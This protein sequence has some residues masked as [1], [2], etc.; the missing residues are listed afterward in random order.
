MKWI[1]R[2]P[3]WALILAVLALAV[4]VFVVLKATKPAPR[5]A[6]PPAPN[7]PVQVMEVQPRDLTLKVTGLGTVAPRTPWTALAQVGGEIVFLSENL[8]SGGVVAKGETLIRID[9]R[10]YRLAVERLDAQVA[11]A[12]EELRNLEQQKKNL[13]ANLQIAKESTVLSRRSLERAEELLE[14][15]TG[16]EAQRD[17]A[18]ASLLQS[19]TQR[20][21][22]ENQLALWPSQ[23]ARS[24]QYL[25]QQQAMLK[26]ARIQLEDTEI[27]APFAGRVTE[28]LREMGEY[29][30]PGTA[31]ARLYE[32]EILEIPVPLSLE[33]IV[34]VDTSLA[35]DVTASPEAIASAP[36]AVVR[37]EVATS[38]IEWE[39]WLARAGNELDRQSR[40]ANLIVAVRDLEGRIAGRDAGGV[41]QAPDLLPGSFVRVTIDGHYL[42]DIFRIPRGLLNQH[43]E[44]YLARE[45]TLHVQ[46][47]HVLHTSEDNAYI[48]EGLKAGDQII[49]S[50]VAAP[51]EGMAVRI[52][53]KDQP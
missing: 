12:R 43:D 19:L 51:V 53:G 31:L 13:E 47:V 16:S 42:K 46:K 1:A 44:V 36:K 10:S 48:D 49:T 2:L 8:R 11:Q 45:G 38:T 34:R 50:P 22:Y 4:L 3:Q 28:R 14:T 15:R 41:S 32:P 21:N 18:E 25:K 27:V 29:V 17:A 37:R 30:A 7:L 52:Q 40:T 23:Y 5:Q 26:E 20:Q 33:A 24:E 35:A 9:P 6:K 39:G